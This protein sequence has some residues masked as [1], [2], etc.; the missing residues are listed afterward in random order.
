LPAKNL[1]S[2]VLALFEAPIDALSHACLFPEFEGDRLSLGGISDV[3]LMAFLERNPRI[4][5][6]SLCLDNDGAGQTAA[7]KIHDALVESHPHIAVTIDPPITGK[8]YNDQLLH[9]MRLERE[10][11]VANRDQDDH[12]IS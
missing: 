3:A 6:I 4:R 1:N 5:E 7:R 2:T 8:D 12:T 11:G 10:Q 9:A